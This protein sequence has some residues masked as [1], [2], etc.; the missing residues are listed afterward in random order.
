MNNASSESIRLHSSFTSRMTG[1]CLLLVGWMA[2]ASTAFA[3][4]LCTRIAQPQAGVLAE[5]IAEIACRENTLWHAP[6]ID[7]KGRLASVTVVEAENA[8]LADGATPAWKRVVDYWQGSGL[9]PRMAR[10]PGASDCGY[11]STSQYPLPGCRAFVV[12]QPWSAAFVSWVMVRAGVPGFN[13]SSSHVNYVRD[14]YRSPA[15][16]PF[17]F[18]DIDTEK[19]APGDLL[20]YVREAGNRYGFEGLRTF[21]SSSDSGGLKMHCDIVIAANPG[22]DG[23]MYLVGGNVLQGV[24]LRIFAL[25]RNGMIWGLPRGSS[26]GCAPD[27]PALCSFSRQD[28][29]VLLKLKQ[30]QPLAVPDSILPTRPA[31]A[32]CCVNCVVGADVPRCPSPSGE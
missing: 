2:I 5:R 17:R 10:F 16:S 21:L 8:S 7:E 12:D 6:F 28:W 9:L 18:A 14:A 4:D 31:Q 23:H 22:G 32:Q 11:S 25:N 19:A 27:N 15:T 3:S 13:P 26:S 30:L 29:A 1:I 20:C 24:T